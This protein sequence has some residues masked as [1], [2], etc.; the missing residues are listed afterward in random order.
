[1]SSFPSG[2]KR[3]RN[4]NPRARAPNISPR[5]SQ[6]TM[7]CRQWTA[8]AAP[9]SLYPAI[10]SV[11]C[12][13]TPR[14][15]LLRTP[16]GPD[17]P[18]L[19]AVGRLHL[20]SPLSQQ[21]PVQNRSSRSTSEAG[22]HPAAPTSAGH[23]NQASKHPALPP[24]VSPGVTLPFQLCELPSCPR[25]SP[26]GTKVSSEQRQ[27]YSVNACSCSSSARAASE[28]QKS[29]SDESINIPQPMPGQR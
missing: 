22:P 28:S 11:P 15:R 27:S 7:T 14:L 26:L 10:S 16:P 5:H 1:M 25:R 20:A 13:P 24:T 9:L 12:S 8:I 18:H 17:M 23:H 2:G 29:E 3:H 4:R 19:G 6:I 21:C